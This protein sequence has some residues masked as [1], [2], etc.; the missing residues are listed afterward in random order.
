MRAFHPFTFHVLTDTPCDFRRASLNKPWRAQLL[1]GPVKRSAE[2]RDEDGDVEMSREYDDKTVSLM[3]VPC[4]IELS[5]SSLTSLYS[6][7]KCDPIVLFFLCL[8][9]SHHT[10]TQSRLPLQVVDLLSPF[11]AMSSESEA[12][13]DWRELHLCLASLRLLHANF[14][15]LVSLRHRHTALS[16][17]RLHTSL[18]SLSPFHPSTCMQR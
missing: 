18:L 7:V 3:D 8:L 10:H 9:P 11:L 1:L 13:P 2:A 15:L 12:E 16:A 6:L 17:T 4:C 5:R 14:H